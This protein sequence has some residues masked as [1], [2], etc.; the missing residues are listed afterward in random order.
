MRLLHK[1]IALQTTE[2]MYMQIC[3]HEASYLAYLNMLHN[4]RLNL[5]HKT[6]QEIAAQSKWNNSYAFMLC[7][8]SALNT[9]GI[10]SDIDYFFIVADKNDIANIAVI[11]KALSQ[12]FTGLDVA[13]N[14]AKL[15]NQG[16]EA[17]F[18]EAVLS[19]QVPGYFTND[20]IFRNS[21]YCGSIVASDELFAANLSEK[22]ELLW[23]EMRSNYSLKELL[24]FS[25]QKSRG[26]GN[27]K[28]ISGNLM[29]KVRLIKFMHKM[30]HCVFSQE[31]QQRI[32][33][34]SMTLLRLRDYLYFSNGCKD[35][36]FSAKELL[37]YGLFLN[38]NK[39]DVYFLEANDFL[40]HIIKRVM[41]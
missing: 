11:N 5:F 21:F 28:Y 30:E 4:N 20:E 24:A 34:I 13:Q 25:Y 38:I 37:R 15:F 26:V 33:D 7:G 41:G 19:E 27:Q 35:L 16:K 1:T 23:K 10:I 3:R 6:T 18:S 8:S 12:S 22:R 36:N 31:K 9:M 17:I 39:L 32:N 2:S 14:L 40:D 29:A